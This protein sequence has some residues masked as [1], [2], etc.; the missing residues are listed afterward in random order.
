MNI[1]S[2]LPDWLRHNRPWTWKK[3]RMWG[4]ELHFQFWDI[5][6]WRTEI[7]QFVSNSV[8]HC[9]TSYVQ[10]VLRWITKKGWCK[11]D[12]FMSMQVHQY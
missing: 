1:S 2:N 12:S 11:Q 5:K 9:F 3:R 4:N 10:Y 7:K 6:I 8:R